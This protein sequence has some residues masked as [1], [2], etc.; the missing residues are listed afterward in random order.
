[1]A[2]IWNI[3]STVGSAGFVGN[4]ALFKTQ[5]GIEVY[6]HRGTVFDYVGYN[7]LGDDQERDDFSEQQEL[8]SRWNWQWD[9]CTGIMDDRR[10]TCCICGS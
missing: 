9:I 3:K 10:G 2:S 4:H 5:R 7:E 6:G 1:M 8:A